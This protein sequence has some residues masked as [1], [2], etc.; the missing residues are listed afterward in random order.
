MIILEREFKDDFNA[1]FY[2]YGIWIALGIALIILIV[3]L[4]LIFKNKINKPNNSN[5]QIEVNDFYESLGGL[6]NI[7]TS[8]LN[9]SRFTVELIDNTLLNKEAL[10]LLGVNN[11]IQMSNKITL[12]INDDIK[13]IL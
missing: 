5:K 4:F 11:I 13:Q 3:L 6:T 12:V 1:F 2:N 9:G 10:K 7:K 8:S